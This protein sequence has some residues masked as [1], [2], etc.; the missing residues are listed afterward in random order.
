MVRYNTVGGPFVL[1]EIKYA[2]FVA[3]IM[4]H[5]REAFWEVLWWVCRPNGLLIRMNTSKPRLQRV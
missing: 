1:D 5:D 2:E 3:N 4:N